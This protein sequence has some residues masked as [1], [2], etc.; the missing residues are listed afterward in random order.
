MRPIA[1][2]LGKGWSAPPGTSAARQERSAAGGAVR[3]LARDHDP[4][5]AASRRHEDLD[6]GTD[7][8]DRGPQV[9]PQA[10]LARWRG[11]DRRGTKVGRG[12]RPCGDGVEAEPLPVVGGSQLGVAQHAAHRVDDLHLRIGPLRSV[13]IGVEGA[14][15]ATA[16][17]RHLIGRGVRGDP[18]QPVHV[19]LGGIGQQGLVHRSV[20][21]GSASTEK[22]TAAF[23]AL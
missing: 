3:V 22:V 5:G 4:A 9:A 13:A 17:Q 18:Q 16:G 15:Q 19:A 11:D 14:R 23:D 10:G 2:Y 12:D 20:A 8:H 6:S 21:H 7:T 1:R